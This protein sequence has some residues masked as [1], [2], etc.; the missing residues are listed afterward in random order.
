[1]TN[2]VQQSE[3]SGDNA[4]P[5]IWLIVDEIMHAATRGM[6]PE[7]KSQVQKSIRTLLRG[8]DPGR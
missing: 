6:T 8:Q 3:C 7:E 1:M 5:D 2:P 4:Q